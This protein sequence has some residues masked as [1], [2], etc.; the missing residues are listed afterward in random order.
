MNS[1]LHDGNSEFSVVQSKPPSAFVAPSAKVQTATRKVSGSRTGAR[2]CS[3][4]RGA[5]YKNELQVHSINR[6]RILKRTLTPTDDELTFEWKVGI[7]ARDSEGSSSFPAVQI[8]T[9]IFPA[10]LMA[11]NRV[12]VM[13]SVV[14]AD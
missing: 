8:I 7:A 4:P 1:E 6:T 12:A 5:C 9:N 2:A 13:S 14:T 11:S 3:E 10:V